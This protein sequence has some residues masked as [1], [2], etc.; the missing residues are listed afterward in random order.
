MPQGATTG[1]LP[2]SGA[3]A[4][5]L[6]TT[7]TSRPLTGQA[8]PVETELDD[9][10]RAEVRAF[11]TRS[12]T[13]RRMSPTCHVGRPGGEQVRLPG[14]PERDAQALATDL[15]VRALDGLLVRTDV[16]AWVCR[17]GPLGR[18]D[19][20]TRWY[21]AARAGF[22]RHGL[23]LPLFGVLNRTGWL[24]LVSGER[25]EWSRLRASPQPES[26]PPPWV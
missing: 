1:P 13:T 24:D 25:H 23:D 5:T 11:V 12:G 7:E 4:A 20:E 16:C 21:A 3:A 17:P 2:R 14:E 22:A 26:A 6:W 8:G 18:G 9:A 15:V 10:L 19:V